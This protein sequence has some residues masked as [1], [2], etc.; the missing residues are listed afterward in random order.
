MIE[1]VDTLGTQALAAIEIVGLPLLLAIFVLKG[2]LV[3]KIIPT[4]IVLPGYVLLV[5]AS[6][7]DGLVIVLGVTGAHLLGQLVVFQGSRWYGPE[8]FAALPGVSI[9][10]EAGIFDRLDTWFESYG[11]LAVFATNVIPWTRG[12]IAIPAGMS[13]YPISK[14]TFHTITSSGISHAAYVLIPLVG[15]GLLG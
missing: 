11:S 2:A 5:G 1:A 10:L 12:L 4:S 15:I 3:G 14:Y 13:S 7:W 6:Y 9:D 8:F